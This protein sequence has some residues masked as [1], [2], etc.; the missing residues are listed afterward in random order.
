MKIFKNP[1]LYKMK[2]DSRRKF[3]KSSL[4]ITGATLYG[5]E[6]SH[7]GNGLLTT[8]KSSGM[9]QHTVYFWL[10]SNAGDQ[11]RKD[12]EQGLKTLVGDV[13]EVHK[14]EIG[15]PAPTPSRDVVDNSFDYSIFTWFKQ[16][17]DHD[18]YQ[19]HPV[20]K[21]F[22]EKYAHLWEK[23]QVHDSVLI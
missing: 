21:K 3:L 12:F 6:I 8:T 23:V 20:H 15:K 17:V 14:S 13:K 11:D 4:L 16:I 9:L 1:Y 2:M 7:A 10:K 19:E 18:T 22:I 5:Y